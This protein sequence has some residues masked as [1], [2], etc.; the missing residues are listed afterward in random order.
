MMCVQVV[1]ALAGDLLVAFGA[2]VQSRLVCKH[3]LD[4]V[5]GHVVAQPLCAAVSCGCGVGGER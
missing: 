1:Q 4:L 2:H 5:G 3:T